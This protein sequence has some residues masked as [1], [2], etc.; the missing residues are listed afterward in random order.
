MLREAN[1]SQN[2]STPI[3]LY[4]LAQKVDLLEYLRESFPTDAENKLD[5][6]YERRDW[7][8]RRYVFMNQFRLATA[9]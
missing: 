4:I 7:S 8:E 6:Y 2:N 1:S 9:K 3:K 5:E